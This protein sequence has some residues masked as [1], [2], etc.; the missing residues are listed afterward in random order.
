VLWKSA[1]PSTDPGRVHGQ[2]PATTGTVTAVRQLLP[3]PLEGV[4]PLEAYGTDDRS[5]VGDRPW[6]MANMVASTDGATAVDGVS[7]GLGGDGDLMVFTALRTIADVILVAS[8][9]AN[10]ERYGPARTDARRTAWRADRGRPPAARIAVVTGSLSIDPQLPLFTDA[11]E[12]HDSERPLVLTGRDA[13]A[14]RRRALAEVAEIV[15]VGDEGADMPTALRV[16]RRRGAEVVLV[17]GG[18]GLLGQMVTADLVDELCLTLSPVLA[19]GDSRRVIH[20]AEPGLRR[21]HL[22]RL[23]EH[24]GEL[25]LRYVR[26]P[27]D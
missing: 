19:G 18:P 1:D 11:D 16:L 2:R 7:G 12:R 25:F 23:L 5:P 22:D 27:D 10:A 21:L 14:E 6:V 26:Q 20:G 17:E 15:E 3:T 4:D 8:G 13:P 24:D 9:T